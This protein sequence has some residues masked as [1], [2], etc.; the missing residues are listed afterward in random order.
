MSALGV[1]ETQEHHFQDGSLAALGAAVD[2]FVASDLGD[3][4]VEGV[5]LDASVRRFD[6]HTGEPVRVAAKYDAIVALSRWRNP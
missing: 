1:Q 5:S 2:A 3:W 6:R 4:K